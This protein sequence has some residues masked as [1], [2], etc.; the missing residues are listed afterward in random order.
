MAS[1]LDA[2]L[3]PQ[4]L[5]HHRS[6]CCCCRRSAA[7][8]PQAQCSAVCCMP[9]QVRTA[10]WMGMRS[11]GRPLTWCHSKTPAALGSLEPSGATG[12]LV[13]C[14]SPRC[15]RPSR[16]AAAWM[17]RKLC[18][19]QRRSCRLRKGSGR[20]PP[21]DMHLPRLDNVRCGSQERHLQRCRTL[22]AQAN[23]LCAQPRHLGELPHQPA[24][25]APA[26]SDHLTAVS[27]RLW[28]S[29]VTRRH[30][31]L[32]GAPPSALP[33]TSLALTQSLTHR[34]RCG[35]WM[36]WIKRPPFTTQLR[37]RAAYSPAA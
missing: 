1:P 4:C 17:Q 22:F 12:Q 10:C 34:Q 21:A 20:P 33:M 6:T 32:Q 30:A 14:C 9:A 28:V 8:Q 36:K 18:L 5:A 15:A 13:A 16:V 25:Q 31:A 11:G 29:S 23:N 37:C 27:P 19:G 2:L 7:L 24:L 3:W 35:S 26:S